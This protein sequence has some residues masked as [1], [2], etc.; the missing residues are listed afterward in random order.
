MTSDKSPIPQTKM[1]LTW[2]KKNLVNRNNSI[3]ETQECIRTYGTHKQ[4]MEHS[5]RNSMKYMR[6]SG[7]QLT[8]MRNI[9]GISNSMEAFVQKNW[10]GIPYTP[11]R[12]KPCKFLITINR[13]FLSGGMGGGPPPHKIRKKILWSWKLTMWWYFLEVQWIEEIKGS[14]WSPFTGG[15]DHSFKRYLTS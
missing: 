15:R 3:C 5:L 14:I 11:H 6:N 8:S 7:Q 1:R 12:G 9:T 10:G 4:Y 2:Y 13:V